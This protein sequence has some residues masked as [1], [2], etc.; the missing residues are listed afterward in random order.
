MLEVD[1]Y[2]YFL[3][4]LFLLFNIIRLK[5]LCTQNYRGKGEE[6]GK[7]GRLAVDNES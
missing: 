4:N 6:E 2:F 7:T 1:C 3:F 5:Y